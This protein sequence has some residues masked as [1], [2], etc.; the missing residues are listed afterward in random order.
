M[1]RTI[2]AIPTFYEGYVFRSRLEV[3]WAYTLDE[4]EVP[5][6]YEYKVFETP[7]GAYLPDFYLPE[8]DIWLEIKPLRPNEDEVAKLVSVSEQVDGKC[9]F[10]IGFPR[11]DG[12]LNLAVGATLAEPGLARS[13]PFNSY[14]QLLSKEKQLLAYQIATFARRSTR[15]PVSFHD[16]AQIELDR[17]NPEGRYK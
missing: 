7:K 9:Y 5:W 8:Q 6:L 14:L 11:F 1:N 17:I 3:W 12:P 4:V 10:T 16:L 2:D 15:N 13:I